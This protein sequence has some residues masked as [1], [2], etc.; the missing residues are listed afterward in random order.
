MEI[1]YAKQIKRAEIPAQTLTHPDEYISNITAF[2]K[3]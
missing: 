1:I 2:L 3:R